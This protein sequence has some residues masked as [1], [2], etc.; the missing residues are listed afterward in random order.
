LALALA[1]LVSAAAHAAGAADTCPYLPQFRK[2]KKEIAGMTAAPALA[3]LSRYEADPE[4]DNPEACE[5]MALHELMSK[6]ET[7]LVFLAGGKTKLCAQS[8][9]R[10]DALLEGTEKCNGIFE[11]GTAHPRSGGI[12]PRHLEDTANLRIE[13]ALPGARLDSVYL[14]PIGDL[15]DGKPATK[16]DATAGE[17]TLAPPHGL[18]AL[19]VI[20]RA[21]PPWSYRKLVWYFE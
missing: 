20:F 18:T 21:P 9:C 3:A 6:R 1:L 7:K 19:M 13:S 14:A 8:A 11:D 10:C 12:R 16:L 15:I 17:I 4:N 2:L 5:V